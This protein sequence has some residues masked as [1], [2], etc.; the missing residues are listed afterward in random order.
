MMQVLIWL[1]TMVTVHLSLLLKEGILLWFSFEHKASLDLA[2]KVGKTPLIS[3]SQNGHVEVVKLLLAEGV[4][5]DFLDPKGN[6]GLHVACENGHLEVVK[7]LVERGA[8]TVSNDKSG[9]DAIGITLEAGHV[10]ITDYLSKLPVQNQQM[11]IWK[12]Y[13]CCGLLVCKI[14]QRMRWLEQLEMCSWRWWYGCMKLAHE[15][16]IVLSCGMLPAMGTL[17]LSSGFIKMSI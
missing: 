15:A 13:G 16:V 12:C 10:E 3:A 4:T 5:I 1:M 11:D 17:T 2:N 9:R 14:V 6:T 7:R 8:S